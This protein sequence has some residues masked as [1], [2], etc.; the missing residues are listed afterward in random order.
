M[1]ASAPESDRDLPVLPAET[2]DELFAILFGDPRQ[3][4]QRLHRLLAQ[5]PD[6]REQIAAHVAWHDAHAHPAPTR[7]GA[8]TQHEARAAGP[9]AQQARSRELDADR[10]QQIGPYRI[11]G[12]LGEGGMGIVYLAEQQEPLRLRVALKL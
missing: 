12:T 11:L 10:P 6:H 5:A 8:A 4:E 1:N 9:G 7:A 2:H 3:R